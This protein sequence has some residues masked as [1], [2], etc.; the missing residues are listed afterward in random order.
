M[1]SVFRRKDVLTAFFDLDD[2][3]VGASSTNN[4]TLKTGC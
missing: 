4:K 3:G 1:E 2:S